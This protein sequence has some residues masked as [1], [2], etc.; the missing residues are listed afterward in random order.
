MHL[1]PHPRTLRSATRWVV[2]RLEKGHAMVAISDRPSAAPTR[3]CASNLSEPSPVDAA[4]LVV[5]FDGSTSATAAL[6]WAG[7]TGMPVIVVRVVER[8]QAQGHRPDA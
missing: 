8:R 4:P 3:E 1:G 2:V 5:G 6:V 7:A